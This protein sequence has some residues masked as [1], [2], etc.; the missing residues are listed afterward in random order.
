MD[1]PDQEKIHIG[2][3]GLKG[4]PA[5]G[6]AASVGQGLINSLKGKFSFT[7]YGVRSHTDKPGPQDGFYQI[8]FRKFPIKKL[9]IF[10][11]YFKSALHA[12]VYG[13]YD[14]I[15]L[16]HTDGA[17]ILPLLRL[18]YKVLLTAH[19]QPQLAEKWPGYVKFFFR[20]NE[21]I[22]IRFANEFS[23]VGKPLHTKFTQRYTREFHYIPN[24]IDLNPHTESAVEYR[25]Y[26][27][28]AAG[29]IIPLKGLHLLLEA[30]KMIN[31]KKKLLVLGDMN[32]MPAYKTK[33]LN[34]AKSMDVEFPGLIKDKSKVLTYLRHARLFIFP[35]YS[36]NMSMMLL[37]AASMKTPIICSD[38]EENRELF[39]EN[40]VTFFRSNDAR[41]LSEKLAEYFKDE[42]QTL[43]KTNNAHSRLKN[44]YS[45]TVIAPKYEVLYKKMAKI[46]NGN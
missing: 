16:H 11:Y 5:F 23:C 10:F 13:R 18:K 30:L 17:I 26:L 2:I 12:L 31:F 3:I 43:E 33:I 44:I 38:I 46:S 42:K 24:G 36:E 32:Q 39:T 29:R 20:L 45:W 37:E 7:V 9:N 4:L 40:E 35:S 28:F 14:L 15:H 27:L 1:K 34:L 6:G 21:R 8:V 41:D 25:D 22:A 19:A